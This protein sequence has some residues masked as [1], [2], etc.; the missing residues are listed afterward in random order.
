MFSV[1]DPHC[2]KTNTTL[3]SDAAV[4]CRKYGQPICL[5]AVL[6]SSVR[7]LCRIWDARD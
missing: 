2:A 6:D 3:D 1:S 4:T 7:I 5:G